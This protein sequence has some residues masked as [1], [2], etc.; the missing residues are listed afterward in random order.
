MIRIASQGRRAKTP[1]R[2]HLLDG[3]LPTPSQKGE[4]FCG[5]MKAMSRQRG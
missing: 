4:P 3:I 5:R 1:S 2:T